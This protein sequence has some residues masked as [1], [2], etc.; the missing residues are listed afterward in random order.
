MYFTFLNWFKLLRIEGHRIMITTV[1]SRG[2]TVV[3]AR[4]RHIFN[5]KKDSRI[6]WIVEGKTIK[7]SPLPN[8]TIK[9]ARGIFPKNSHLNDVLLS[10]RRKERKYK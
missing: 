7:V 2:Q 5:I 3:P 9:A 6:D 1:T 10:E 4:I 8:D